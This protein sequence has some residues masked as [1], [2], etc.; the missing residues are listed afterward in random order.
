[1]AVKILRAQQK[2]FG[3]LAT[4]NQLAKYGSFAAG[5]PQRYDGATVTPANIQ[6]IS[7]FLDGWFGAVVG[8]NSPA[9]EDMNALC[10]LFAY[11]LGYILQTGVGEYD[12]NTEYFIGSLVNDGFGHLYVSRTDNNLGNILTSQANWAIAGN[13]VRTVVA[14]GAILV[15][16]DTVRADA[17][18][19]PGMINTLPPCATTPIGKKINYKNVSTNG[20][21]SVL[22][23]NG[24]E[25][26]DNANTLTLDS[27]PVLDS[28]TVQN[29]GTKW[30]II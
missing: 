9:I 19:A 20:N 22:K 26:I 25:L 23:G 4:F 6:A 17:T 24:A 5:I 21:Q 12:A 7:N 10:Y 8:G 13:N 27:D 2:Q 3:S 11:Q 30:D 18:A 16:D 29:M 28:Y 1:M 15:T 14:A